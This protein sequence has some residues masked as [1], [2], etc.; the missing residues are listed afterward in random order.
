[1]RLPEPRWSGSAGRIRRRS[2]QMPVREDP[3]SGE[4]RPRLGRIARD[5]D[6]VVTDAQSRDWVADR[7]D[8]VGF[9]RLGQ[10]RNKVRDGGGRQRRA[11]AVTDPAAVLLGITVWLLVTG[12]LLAVLI[13]V[14]SRWAEAARAS[15]QAE[16]AWVARW[17]E[18]SGAGRW[19]ET[20]GAGRWGEVLM[21]AGVA[22]FGLWAGLVAVTVL[23]RLRRRWDRLDPGGPAPID[24]PYRYAAFRRRVEACAAVARSHRRHATATDLEQALDWLTAAQNE[25]PRRP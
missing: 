23:R 20:F 10:V 16:A 15:R 8:R 22:V 14:A 19:G 21:V 4:A 3:F 24:D 2:A 11:A 13:P 7:A 5:L 9:A 12:T 17:A 18:V 1:M 25:L 6:A